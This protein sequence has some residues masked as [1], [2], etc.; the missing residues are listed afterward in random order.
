MSLLCSPNYYLHKKFC[1]P[2]G[3]AILSE[4]HWQATVL[5]MHDGLTLPLPAAALHRSVAGHLNYCLSKLF[6]LFSWTR[7][8]RKNILPSDC[9]AENTIPMKRNLKSSTIQERGR[10]LLIIFILIH[11]N[12]IL[13][14]F[15]KHLFP[16]EKTKNHF[17]KQQ[18][19]SFH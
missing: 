9:C 10:T 18:K 5:C 2:E 7:L 14:R 11:S 13:G 3:R 16:A 8:S 6:V 12:N 19:N 4:M 1:T 15:L 17:G